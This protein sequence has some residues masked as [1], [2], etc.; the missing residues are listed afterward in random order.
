MDEDG[1]LAF[2]VSECDSRSE[3]KCGFGKKT[4]GPEMRHTCLVGFL[5]I[6]TEC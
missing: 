2:A 3:V 5:C 1:A 6:L 4:S